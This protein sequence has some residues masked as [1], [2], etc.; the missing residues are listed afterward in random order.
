MSC[1]W[2]S[3]IPDGKYAGRKYLQKNAK[4]RSAFLR[5]AAMTTRDC[6]AVCVAW[7]GE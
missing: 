6:G 1:R 3:G 4:F 5:A 7:G 2:N